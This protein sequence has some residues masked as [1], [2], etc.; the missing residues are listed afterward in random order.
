MSNVDN[1]SA[2]LASTPILRLAFRPLF[3][4]G[5]LFSLIA[6]SW[7]AYFWA[8]PFDWQPYGGPIWWHGHEMLFGF[9]A[10]IVVGFL[11]TAVQSWT[12]VPGVKGNKLAVL[13]SAWLLGRLLVAFGAGLPGWVVAVGDLSFLFLSA[14]AM[15]Y[16]VIKVKQWRNLMF[17]PILLVLMMLNAVSHWGTLIGDALVALHS[18]HGATLLTALVITIVG[19]RVIPFFTSSASGY[20]RLPNIGWLDGLSIGSIIAL[21]IVAFIGFS[22]V[23]A[24]LLAVLSLVAAVSNGWRFLR[25][26]IAHTLNIPLLWSLHFSYLFIPVGMVALFLFSMGWLTNI[27]IALHC[28]TVGAMGGMILAMI[29]R[30]TL[31]H[32]GRKLQPPKL[33]TLGYI[34]ILIAAAV[35]VLLPALLPSFTNWGIV[36]AAALWVAAYSIYLFYYAPMLVSARVDGRPG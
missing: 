31:G 5:T 28:F 10:A 33:M 11:L 22:V 25:W 26:G 19:G 1:T 35:R 17:V 15:A 36:G 32:T 24:P 14:L 21:V 2:A 6:I 20:T 9:G 23:P 3:L 29:S 13:A 7:W 8:S 27:S 30:V 4:G 18:L 12:G 16:P 34:L